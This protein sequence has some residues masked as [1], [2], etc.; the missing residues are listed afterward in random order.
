VG[1]AVLVTRNLATCR[2][3]SGQKPKTLSGTCE[4]IFGNLCNLQ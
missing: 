1:G 3:E 2:T 4:A